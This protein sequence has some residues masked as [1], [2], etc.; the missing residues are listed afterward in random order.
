M[1]KL[2]EDTPFGGD[3]FDL[4]DK[5]RSGSQSHGAGRQR[6]KRASRSSTGSKSRTKLR[7]EAPSIPA[8]EWSSASSVPLGAKWRKKLARGTLAAALLIGTGH[9]VRESLLHDPSSTNP[10]ASLTADAEVKG[11]NEVKEKRLAE[12]NPGSLIWSRS[13]D[14]KSRLKSHDRPIP[15]LEKQTAPTAER[16]SISDE[17]VV[18]RGQIIVPVGLEEGPALS[19]GQGEKQETSI[20]RERARELVREARRALQNGNISEAREKALIARDLNVPFGILEDRP[21]AVLASID[22]Q[23]GKPALVSAK[24]SPAV[25]SPETVPPPVVRSNSTVPGNILLPGNHP[26][27]ANS[28]PQEVIITPGETRNPLPDTGMRLSFDF[29]GAPWDFVLTQFAAKIGQPLDMNLIP[30]GALTYVDH[31]PRSAQ[32]TLDLLNALLLEKGFTLS[33]RDGRLI[34]RPQP[35]AIASRADATEISTRDDADSA[36]PSL[37][38]VSTARERSE[39]LLNDARH[40]LNTGRVDDARIKAATASQL[41]VT[42]G[43]FADRPE[44]VLDELNVR[45]TEATPAPVPGVSPGP[46]ATE[47][48]PGLP[49]PSLTETPAPVLQAPPAT[50][51]IEVDKKMSF[52]FREA[53]WEFVLREYAR[54]VRLPLVMPEPPPGTFTYF[55]SRLFT[56]EETRELLNQ[57]LEKSGYRLVKENDNLVVRKGKPALRGI[58]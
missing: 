26:A 19:I 52:S 38:L 28:A 6:P 36:A 48:V 23:T 3:L 15:R 46:A 27:V 8:V 49:G 20:L 29:H 45:S 44:V 5:A 30:A 13:S 34:L 2:N 58:R 32:E 18:I 50:A 22:R 25:S 12:F 51:A 31:Q 54:E 37:G 21:E 47:V 24:G 1:K 43:L 4:L 10:P 57:F 39:A 14:Q 9:V 11:G 7:I 40:D 53:A 17:P 55:D 42:Y 16:R 41:N 33:Q 56:P 35:S